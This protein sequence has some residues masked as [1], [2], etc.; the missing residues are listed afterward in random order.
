MLKSTQTDAPPIAFEKVI[1]LA[2][3]EGL[4]APYEMRSPKGESGSYWIHSKS[5][6]RMEQ[7]ELV[8]DQYTGHILKRI[9]FAKAPVV[10]KQFP[11]GFLFIR[12]NFTV[13]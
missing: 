5:K 13:R 8:I 9:E 4:K 11:G 6:R 12:V 2:K 1:D 3:A 7:N 10:A